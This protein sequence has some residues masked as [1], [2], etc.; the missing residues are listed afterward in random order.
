MMRFERRWMTTIFETILPQNAHPALRVGA[1][2][3]D[4]EPF[5]DSYVERLPRR[6]KRDLRLIV[7]V[8]TWFPLFFIGLPLPLPWLSEKNRARYLEKV[9]M[10]R[11]YL[12]R[13]GILLL[14]STIGLVY[15][16]DPRVRS[17]LEIPY[18]TDQVKVLG[19][20]SIHPMP[21][22]ATAS[23][24]APGTAPA[25]AP[26]PASAPASAPALKDAR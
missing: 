2:D 4:L 22:V 19:L 11:V 3:L 21:V 9:A 25:P 8:L 14:K 5:Y 18:S 6:L 1:R 15:F 26:A 10:S 16:R 24:P 17:V 12:L 13:Q 20:P 23:P 7:W